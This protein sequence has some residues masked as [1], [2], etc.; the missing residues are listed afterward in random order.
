[1]SKNIIQTMKNIDAGD[2]ENLL[3]LGEAIFLIGSSNEFYSKLYSRLY[4]DLIEEFPF[5]STICMKTLFSFAKLFET[6]EY[7]PPEDDYDKF[8]AINKD[9]EKRRALS[10]FFANLM[11]LDIIEK[12]KIYKLINNLIEKQNQYFADKSKKKIIDEISEIED[13]LIPFFGFFTQLEVL[14]YNILIQTKNKIECYSAI[15]YWIHSG[16]TY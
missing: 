1:M 15:F 7:I 3:K 14:R 2:E 11:L 5:M 6:I 13:A 16:S 12:D 10:C 9:N 8:C 4:K